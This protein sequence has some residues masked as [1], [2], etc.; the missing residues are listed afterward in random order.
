MKLL[1]KDKE[2]VLKK[3]DEMNRYLAELDVI[4]P[5]TKESYLK[6]LTTKRACEKTIELAIECV[7]DVCSIIVSSLNLGI[8]N[9]EED[10]FDILERN[11]LLS[12]QMRSSLDNMKG[13]RN[14]MV[15]RYGV[16]NDPMAY[17]FLKSNLV[18]FE[19]FER[20]IRKLL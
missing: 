16:V 18:D 8:P 17:K 1:P 12:K 13:F 9:D 14:L 2:K 11:K 6:N 3:L 15:H 20:E 4:L 5:A 7:I 10:I 19:G